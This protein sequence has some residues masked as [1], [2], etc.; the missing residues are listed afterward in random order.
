MTD[1][2]H[3][4]MDPAAEAA[5]LE[6]L[7][8]DLRAMPARI[9]RARQLAQEA[10]DQAKERWAANRAELAGHR[11]A[12]EELTAQQVGEHEARKKELAAQRAELAEREREL[13]A[14]R[15]RVVERERWVE[16]RAAD[17][18]RRYSGAA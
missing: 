1:P 12:I 14:E 17:M 9:K 5:L 11:A 7:A 10:D 6:Q 2:E 8:N 18:Q 15:Q 13:A 3:T 4:P 16:H